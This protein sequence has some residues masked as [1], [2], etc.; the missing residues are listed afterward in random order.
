MCIC[1]ESGPS[2]LSEEVWYLVS[3]TIFILSMVMFNLV[4]ILYR[5]VH[6]NV[7]KMF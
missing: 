6:Q 1:I 2:P 7:E 3:Q 4:Q 5:I